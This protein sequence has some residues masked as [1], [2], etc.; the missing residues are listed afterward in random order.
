ML[1]L[2]ESRFDKYS[3][4]DTY[5]DKKLLVISGISFSIIGGIASWLIF[6]KYLKYREKKDNKRDQH[7][8]LLS[9]IQNRNP[10]IQQGI[11]TKICQHNSQFFTDS[12]NQ[13]I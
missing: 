11:Q 4:A 3:Q 2:A 10:K 12:K 5:F 7:I 13:I 8:S 6:D 9:E 1:A